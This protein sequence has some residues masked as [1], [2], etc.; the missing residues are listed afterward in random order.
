MCW[1]GCDRLRWS[2]VVYTSTRAARCIG[3][4]LGTSS[5]F[6]EHSNVVAWIYNFKVFRGNGLSG[7]SCFFLSRQ[8]VFFLPDPVFYFVIGNKVDPKFFTIALWWPYRAVQ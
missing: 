1:S 7:C 4:W 5:D 2:T 6:L 3:G 8:R